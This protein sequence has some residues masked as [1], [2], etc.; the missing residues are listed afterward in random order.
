MSACLP[1]HPSAF[2]FPQPGTSLRCFPGCWKALDQ[3]KRANLT[4]ISCFLNEYTDSWVTILAEQSHL[5]RCEEQVITQ[6]VSAPENAGIP[7]VS[8]QPPPHN[9]LLNPTSSLGPYS[10]QALYQEYGLA[11]GARHFPWRH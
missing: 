5:L 8:S 6:D 4:Q 11:L 3:R 10:L 1:A 2:L 7:C 9:A